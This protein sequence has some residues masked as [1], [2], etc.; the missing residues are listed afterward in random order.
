MSLVD[1][2]KKTD[3]RYQY[4]LR[5]LGNLGASVKVE[6]KE[7]S[8]FIKLI[9]TDKKG[10]RSVHRLTRQGCNDCMLNNAVHCLILAYETDRNLGMCF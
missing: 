3:T 8:Q 9:L 2:W 6:D 5:R 4:N 7:T 1:Q 10:Y